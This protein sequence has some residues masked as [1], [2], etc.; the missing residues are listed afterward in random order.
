MKVNKN[1]TQKG[2]SLFEVLFSVAITALI[3]TGVVSLATSAVRNS[4]FSRNNS[5]AARMA[6]EANEW[7]RSQ[8]DTDW[9]TFYSYVSSYQNY[10]LNNLNWTNTGSCNTSSVSDSVGGSSIF[11][12]E[13]NFMCGPNFNN[14]M[15]ECV[16]SDPDTIEAQV[17]VSWTDSQGEHTVS[18]STRFTDWTV[19]Y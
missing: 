5:V 2:Q 18:T 12:R 4:S 15:S 3:L 13:V 17:S 16:T 6:Q 10:C 14:W 8:R 1:K 11:F 7:L 19:T 9:A